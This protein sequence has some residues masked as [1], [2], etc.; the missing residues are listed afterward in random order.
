[1]PATTRDAEEFVR[2]SAPFL[3][4][5]AGWAEARRPASLR[6]IVASAGSPGNVALIAVDVV[7][8]FCKE[9]ALASAR[10]GAIVPPIVDLLT[11]AHAAGVPHVALICDTHSPQAEEFHQFAPHCIAGTDE[12]EPVDE[13]KALP[14]Y[15]TFYL[16]R[17]NSISPWHS[18]SDLAGWLHARQRDG[19]SAVLAVGD[20]TDLCLHE[21]ALPLKLAANHEDR[22]LR[23]VVPVDCVQTYDLPVEAAASLGTLPH[24]GDLLHEIFLYHL[25][26]NGVEVISHI[27]D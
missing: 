10:V 23:V 18:P 7:N 11:R 26:L 3:R 1:M 24:H 9:G 8:G 13:L 2:S 17:K 19:V 27:T 15:D 5:L 6:E 4:Y 16:V 25:A 20:C 22:P 12:A 21:L 14:F